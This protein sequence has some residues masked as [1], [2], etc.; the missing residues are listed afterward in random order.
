M[1]TTHQQ[2]PVHAT[3][4][5][6]AVTPDSLKA[7]SVAQQFFK[8]IESLEAEIQQSNAISSEIES[9]GFLKRMRSS[10]SKDIS[11]IA[12][13][14]NTIN[15]RMVDLIQET[16]RLNMLSYAGLVV[17]MDEMRNGIE[18]GF[19]DANGNITQLGEEGR[20]LAETATDIIS[21][22]LDT[23]RHTQDRIEH[24]AE[25]ILHV[26]Q[27]LDGKV[28]EDA[29]RDATLADLSHR[30]D[31]KDMLDV[32]QDEAISKLEAQFSEKHARAVAR[33]AAMDTHASALATQERGLALI[34]QVI[35]AQQAAADARIDA[36][37]KA[38]RSWRNT[39]T[40]LLVVAFGWLSAIT[41]QVFLR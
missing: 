10:A 25:S 34:E 5:A 20:S 36:L 26:L 13:I 35:K 18:H 38:Q 16:I 40:A 37:A 28:Q 17:L 4:T 8:E 29:V 19:R 27:R 3:N 7:K 39:A 9:R 6:I 14:Q 23:S 22:I 15:K 1:T 24:N 33:D 11:Q 31:A 2:A 21:G 41:W 12:R 32:R 30:A